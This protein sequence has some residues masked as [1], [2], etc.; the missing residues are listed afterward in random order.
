MANEKT[1]S[2]TFPEPD[3]AQLT[4]D[5]PGKGANILSRPVLEELSG[6]LDE[7]EERGDIAGLVIVSAKPNIF[8]AGA[9]LREFAASLDIPA[10]Q[11][12]AM[13]RQGQSLF[14]RLSKATFVTVAAIDGICVGGGAELAVW[15]DR[16]ICSDGPKTEIGF[17]EVKLGLFPGWG[18]TARTPRICGLAN[19]VELVTSGESIDAETAFAMGLISDI[20]P[21]EQLVP[22]AIRLVRLEIETGDYQRDRELWSGPI[23][24]SETEL[25]FLGATASAV[26]QQQTKGHYPAPLA[27][28]EVMMGGAMADVDSAL[29]MEA[30]G[31]SGLFGSSINAS[32][33]NVFFLTDRNKKDSGVEGDVE[34]KTI[35]S[36]AVIGAGIM[37][38]GIAAAN[39]K[40]K[41][42][43]AMTDANEDALRK[44]VSG[45]LEEISYNRKT[46]KAEVDRAVEFA[47][48]VNGTDSDSEIAKCDLVIEAVV[49]KCGRQETNLWS[50]R[51][52]NARRRD[53]RIQHIYHSDY[54]T[55]ARTGTTG[56]LLRHSFLQSGP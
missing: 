16:R 46:K 20:V 42:P 25:G 5:M 30:E 11:T 13:C 33:L 43:V 53:S 54:R 15:C 3:I 45:V 34:P 56:K 50:H 27:A 12:I 10:E 29:Q 8:I 38:A 14:Q 31:M 52:P 18:G 9:D 4:I 32:L 22:A 40:R 1:F 6:I 23:N 36:A 47:P 41:I 21:V 39:A 19:A 48:L 55:C 44:G 26:I 7:L 35:S 17:P 28:L 49:E 24:I 51:T 2:L 37:G